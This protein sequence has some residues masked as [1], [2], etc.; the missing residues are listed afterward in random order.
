M[1]RI[2]AK[3]LGLGVMAILLLPEIAAAVAKAAPVVIVSDTRFSSGWYRWWGQIY[4]DSHVYFTILT[5][6]TIL[7]VGVSFGLITDFFMSKIGID[8]RHREL[9][10]H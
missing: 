10:E 6:A 9:K 1:R 8:L 5:Y 2:W 4:N 3:I 7:V